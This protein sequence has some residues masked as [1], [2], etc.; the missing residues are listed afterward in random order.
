[1]TRPRRWAL[2][3]LPLLLMAGAAGAQPDGGT[4]APHWGYSGEASPAHW[5]DVAALC[6]RGQAQSP[7]GFNTRGAKT[8]GPFPKME[9]DWHPVTG[10]EVDTGH[11]IQVNVPP[12][13]F[14]TYGGTRYELKQ[15]HL[16]SPSEH[17]VNGEHTA[18][19]VH[20]VHQTPEGKTLVLGVLIKTGK[21]NAGLEQVFSAFPPP[22]G[23][24][25]P[26]QIDLPALLPKDR[27][28]FAYSGSLTTPPCT[29]GVQWLVIV[30]QSQV[31]KAQVD[32]FH[33][34]YKA[35]ARPTQAWHGR[36][37]SMSP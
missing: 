30:A 11:S 19:E 9:I 6:S 28:H 33:T 7:I 17:N 20:F 16:H 26:V 22:G 2:G 18:M 36:A 5:G 25:K 31:S 1:M 10:E 32:A 35:N 3:C 12:G 15:F 37:F 13:N 29:E 8:Q 23:P 24:P 27:T 34:R 4:P 21:A 14:L